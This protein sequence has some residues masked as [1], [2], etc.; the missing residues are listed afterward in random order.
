MCQFHLTFF[1]MFLS[2][3]LTIPF[4][5]LLFFRRDLSESYRYRMYRWLIFN[6]I[7][8]DLGLDKCA[9]LLSGAAPMDTET[10]KYFMSFDIP[11]TE[12]SI[13]RNLITKR[14]SKVSRVSYMLLS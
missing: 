12:V 14:L 9:I 7:K 1:I 8:A 13:I 4:T 11:V 5:Q 6:M 3:R 2:Q 10:K